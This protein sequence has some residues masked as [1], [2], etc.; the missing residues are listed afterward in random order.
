MKIKNLKLNPDNPRSIKPEKLEKLANSIRDFPKMMV[1]RPIVYDE[2]KVIIGGNM[3][4]RA[5]QSLGM[6]EIPDEWVSDASDFTPEERHRFVMQDNAEMGEHDYDMVANQ[7]DLEDLDAWGIDVPYADV[8]EEV[9]ED[10]APE[11]SSEPP[12]SQLGVVYQLG[13]H[14]VYCGKADELDKLM[15]GTKANLLLTD[16]PYGV[17]YTDKNEFLNRIGK[18]IASPNPIENDHQTPDEMKEF[19][20]EN[21]GNIF[22]HLANDATYYI[23]SPQGGELLLLLLALYDIGYPSRHMIIWA[24]NNHVLGRCDYNYK[25]EPILYGW[26]DKHKFVGGGKQK[27]SVWEIDKPHSSKEHPTMKPVELFAE[28]ILNSTEKGDLVLDPFL[29]SGTSVMAAEQTDRIC[30]GS[31]LD[32]KYVDVIRKRYTKFISP[33]KELPENWEELTPAISGGVQAK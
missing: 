19:W 26:L 5:I 25:H 9:E 24:K 8:T 28:C 33:D 27:T 22:K 31:E 4:Y 17:S 20:T 16:P 29:G 10:E 2:N 3:R 30:F 18:P 7:Y 6:T 11:V 13:R 15:N 1:K 32:P 12:V 21:F 23:T 14:R